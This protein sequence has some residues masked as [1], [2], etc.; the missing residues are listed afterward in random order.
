VFPRVIGILRPTHARQI[1]I[2]SIEQVYG[3]ITEPRG[4]GRRIIA[5]IVNHR[6]STFGAGVALSIATRWPSVQEDF[7]KW[8]TTN[9]DGF[10]LGNIRE[11][12]INHELSVVSMVAQYGFGDSSKPRIRYSALSQCLSKLAS[13]A[14]DNHASVH[15]PK[16]GT[17]FAGGS[18]D[19]IEELVRENLVG[20]GISV[21]VYLLPHFQK[22]TPQSSMHSFPLS[23]PT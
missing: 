23:K 22:T 3:N 12:F 16:I 4:E 20:Q 5:H 21:L 8:A 13:I 15:M 18:W 10:K 14:K 2:V 7:R 11:S 1:K 9:K 19:M 6:S 17:G